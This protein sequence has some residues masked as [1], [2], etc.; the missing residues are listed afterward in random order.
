MKVLRDSCAL[1]EINHVLQII[2]RSAL[3][4]THFEELRVATQLFDDSLVGFGVR[5][6]RGLSSTRRLREGTQRRA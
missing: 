4:R 3:T 6:R 2:F 1:V 5:S